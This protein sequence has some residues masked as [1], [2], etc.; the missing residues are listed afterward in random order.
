MFLNYT[1]NSVLKELFLC[2]VKNR[3]APVFY[4][5]KVKIKSFAKA[6]LF[7]NSQKKN[8]LPAHYKG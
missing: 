4:Y 2:I 5:D 6:S 7:A 1:N 3:Q 8:A